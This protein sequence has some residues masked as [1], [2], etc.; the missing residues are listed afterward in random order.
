MLSVIVAPGNPERLAGLLSAL[1]PGVVENL[2]REVTIVGDRDPE[3][4]AALCE[5]S[6]ARLAASLTDAVAG[7]RGAWLLVVPPELRMADGWIERLADHL[8]EGVRA[9]RLQGLS[10]GFLKPRAEGVLIASAAAGRAAP[11]GL[12]S[13]VRQLGRGAPRLR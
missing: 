8:R 3:L 11:G 1:V 2:V 7:A 4:L 9:A 6:G 12:P 10:E 5:A 13:L